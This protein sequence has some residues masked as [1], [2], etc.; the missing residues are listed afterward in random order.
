MNLSKKIKSKS[1]LCALCVLCGSISTGAAAQSRQIPAPPQERPVVILNATIH[2]V[3]GPVIEKGW[4]SFDNGK[5]VAT[6]TGK[7]KSSAN[8][9]SLDGSGLHV[10]PGLILASTYLGLTEVGDISQTNDSTELGRV[11]PEVRAACAVNPDSDLI[12][13]TRANGILTAMIFPRGGLIPGRC[14]AM[15][16]DGWTW[17]NMTIDA[18]AGLALNWPRTEPINSPWMDRSEDQQRKEIKDDLDAVEKFF[19][20]AQAYIDAKDAAASSSNSAGKSSAAG[21]GANNAAPGPAT[22]LRYEG[23]RPVLKGEKPIYISAALASQIESAVGWA[24]R[25]GL[26]IVIVGGDQADRVSALLKKHDIPVIITGTHR[27]PTRR[28]DDYDQAYALPAKLQE[29]G[30]RFCITAGGE[31]AHDRNLNHM[32]ATAAAYGLPKEDAL[33]S[34]TS[35]AANILGLADRL[36]TLEPGKSATLIITSGDPLEITTETLIAYIDGRKIDLGSRQ[37]SLYEKY[38][39]KYRQLGLLDDHKH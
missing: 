20:E 14:S 33:K 7:P 5:I 2:P 9:T 15:R 6:G 29:A 31:A 38:R 26:K 37:K 21:S 13:V 11:K 12:P 30:V 19:D 34:V 4:I 3:S 28:Q 10:Y 8:A 27:M 32:A 36:G 35:S 22:D 1:L 17:E 18:D 23:M 39:E 25:R 24:L 16:L